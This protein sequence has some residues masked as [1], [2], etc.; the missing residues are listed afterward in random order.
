MTH[1]FTA[2]RRRFIDCPAYAGRIAPGDVVLFGAGHGS[3]YP[4]SSEM[5]YDLATHS[6]E[7]PEAIRTASIATSTLMSNYDFDQGGPLLDRGQRGLFDAGDLVLDPADG[8]GNRAA[9]EGVTRDIARAGG[10]PILMG[11]D[12]SVPIPFLAGLSGRPLHILQVD[13]HI[14]W[15]DVVSGETRGYSSTMRRASEQPHVRSITQV[16]MRGV[17]SAGPAEVQAALDWGARLVTVDEALQLG[18]G[19]VAGLI[20]EGGEVLIQIDLDAYDT[21]VC[22]A[23]NAPNP[24]GFQFR[25]LAAI[26]KAVIAAH[27]LAGLSVVELVP[28]RDADGNAAAVAARAICNII[29]WAVRR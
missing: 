18:P 17:G 23:V 3:P 7:A 26:L 20:P 19:G 10:V 6:A 2:P 5:G 8:P 22:G 4:A 28:A 1:R 9:I 12:D 21:S 24:G 16:G 11:G 15:R 13:S 25:E 29:G 14:D 27:P